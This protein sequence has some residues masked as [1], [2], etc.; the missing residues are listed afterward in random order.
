MSPSCTMRYAERSSGARQGDRLAVHVESYVEPRGANVS[1]QGLQVVQPGTRR[2]L[3]QVV[4]LPQ[5]TQQ[6]AHLGERRTAGLLDVPQRLPLLGRGRHPVPHRPDLEDHHA[7]RVGDH[8]VELARHPGPLLGHRHPGR[9]LPL[10]LGPQRPLLRGLAPLGPVAQGE[11]DEPGDREEHRGED[12]VCR[13]CGRVVVDDDALRRP[14]RSPDPTRAWSPRRRLPRSTAA[15]IPQ[16]KTPGWV[17]IS[18]LSRKLSAALPIQTNAGAR[19]G[20]AP[21]RQQRQ[22]HDADRG[23]LEPQLQTVRAVRVVAQHRTDRARRRGGDDQDVEAPGREEP[24]DSAHRLNVRQA[25]AVRVLRKE[26]VPGARQPARAPAAS[27]SAR[28]RRRSRPRPGT[29]PCR[30]R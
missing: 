12:E 17:V 7:H 1:R 23:D 29:S 4:A 27:S 5:R 22:E 25:V 19:N 9:R 8:V 24:P 21:A 3:E 11:P 2:E 6:P 15:P 30:P 14:A 16:R 18:W 20:N 13:P 26:D 28:R 10:P